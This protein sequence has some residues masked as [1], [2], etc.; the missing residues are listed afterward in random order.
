MLL[1]SALGVETFEQDILAWFVLMCLVLTPLNYWAT[2]RFF[3][4]PWEAAGKQYPA[5]YKEKI[6]P[7][8]FSSSAALY[9]LAYLPILPPLLWMTWSSGGLDMELLRASPYEQLTAGAW[10]APY[11]D[12]AVLSNSFASMAKDAVFFPDV[13]D[14]LLAAHHLG[15]MFVGPSFLLLPGVRALRAAAFS[16]PIAE[17]GT[18]CYCC[19][20]CWRTLPLYLI[21]MTLSNA[22]LAP[23][24][25][26]WVQENWDEAPRPMVALVGGVCFF[27]ILVRE[28]VC[29]VEVVDEYRRRRKAKAGEP[30][31]ESSVHPKGD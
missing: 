23:L 9:A 31:R 18:A 2:R 28:I 25:W 1:F 3:V 7:W 16:V 6:P 4:L 12:A 24:L 19:F 29:I 20:V 13:P 5:I 17:L 11:L 14:K 22:L 30:K 26:L 15:V 8:S 27:I 10:Y 21:G